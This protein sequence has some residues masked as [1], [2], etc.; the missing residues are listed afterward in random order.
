MT[1]GQWLVKAASEKMGCRMIKRT[2]HCACRNLQAE[3]DGEPLIVSLCHCTECQRRTGSPFGLG[4]WYAKDSVR[5]RGET[6]TF[7]RPIED[8]T[9]TN[10]FCPQVRRHGA[11]GGEQAP[12]AHRYRRR[13]VRRPQLPA[14]GAFH[15]RRDEAPLDRAYG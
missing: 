12:R 7:V 8:R 2:A 10:Y 3:A 9:V 13:H 15:L 1:T 5:I 6:K 4:A 14:A 11:V